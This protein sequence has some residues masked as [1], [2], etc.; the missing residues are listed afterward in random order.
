MQAF[1]VFKNRKE[2]FL[3]T[4]NAALPCIISINSKEAYWPEKW[5]L[6][7]VALLALWNDYR[8]FLCKS[9]LEDISSINSF[10]V[11][12]FFRS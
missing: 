1:T 3:F 5:A 8:P 10:G 12:I 9:V 4:I 6:C 11:S 2:E 7:M